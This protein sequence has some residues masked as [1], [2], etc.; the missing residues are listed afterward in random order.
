MT[1]I[2]K[3]TLQDLSL[4]NLFISNQNENFEKFTKLGWSFNSISSQFEKKNNFAVGY[5]DNNK[6]TGILIGD[7]INYENN[8]E[9]EIHLLYVAKHKRRENIATSLINYIQINKK[10]TNISKIYLEVAENNYKAIRFYSKN[11]FVFSNLRINYY[12]DM[13]K[14]IN[15][16]CFYKFI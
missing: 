9:L 16:K 3:L 5:L 15:A 2:K 8:Y 11:N 6:L 13:N 1:K 10:F 4:I 7:I 12:S 14:K